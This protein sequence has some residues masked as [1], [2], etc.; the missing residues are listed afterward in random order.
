M[1]RSPVSLRGVCFG[2]W[3]FLI[4][5]LIGLWLWPINTASVR[6][7]VLGLLLVFLCGAFFF[8]WRQRVVVY[9]LIALCGLAAAVALW[10]GRG[11]DRRVLRDDYLASLRSYEGSTYLWGGES[12]W[13]IDC[14][15]LVRKAY[16]MALC[17][18]ALGTA[19]PALLRQSVDLWWN[20]TTAREMARGYEGRTI[21]V[22]KCPSLK[23]LDPTALKQGDLAVSDSG[24]HVMAYLGDGMWIGA[25]P[26]EE[27]VTIFSAAATQSGW[28]TIPMQIVR[29]RT[30]AE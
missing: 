8:A 18:Q 17:R 12:G 22:L 3:L 23:S 13:G 25:D 27:K 16:E 11:F 2:L 10:P 9:G 19:N 26:A 28:F 20:D 1:K 6:G 30:L 14:S 7:A 24:T 5:L 29:W 4:P 21:P 15:G